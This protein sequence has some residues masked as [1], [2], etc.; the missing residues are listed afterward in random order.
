M[1]GKAKHFDPDIVDAFLALEER[2]IQLKEDF[3]DE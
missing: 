3:S 1:E 2:F